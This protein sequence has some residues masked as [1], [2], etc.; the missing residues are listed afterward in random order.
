[1]IA[2]GVEHGG[3]GTGHEDEFELLVLGVLGGE[4]LLLP[5]ILRFALR[6]KPLPAG[7]LRERLLATSR[8]LG[9]RANDLLLWDTRQGM[10]NAMVVGLLP[11]CATSFSRTGS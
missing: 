9:F 8:R 3:L 11:G 2:R 10:A 1:M 6:L 7:A 4:F 5:W